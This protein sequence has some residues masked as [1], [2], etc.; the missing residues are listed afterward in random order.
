MALQPCPGS[1]GVSPAP[2]STNQY[3]HPQAHSP[4]IYET[5]AGET[6]ALPGGL[7]F[8]QVTMQ[9]RRLASGALNGGLPTVASSGILPAQHLQALI[10]EGRLFA[11]QPILASQVQPASLDLRLGPVAYRVRASF[12]PSARSRVLDK[13]E[14]FQMHQLDLTTPA[15]LERGCVY[16]VP[17]QEEVDLPADVSGLANP[18]STVGRLDV[19]TRL[20][21]DH[22]DEFER[23]PPGY[24]GQLYAE[25]APRTFSVLV[26]QGTRMNQLRLARGKEET[27]H[28]VL[29]RLHE[30]ETLVYQGN[31]DP[32]EPKI[33]DGLWFSVDLEGEPSVAVIGYRAKRYGPL[34]DLDRVDFYDP[35]EFWEPI[36]RPPRGQLILN[37]EEFYILASKEKIRIPPTYAAE[38]VGYDASV[39]EFRI[40]YAGFFD[41]GFGYGNDDLKG[42]R[43]VLEVRSHE[44][45]FLLE[46]GQRVGRLVYERL[47]EAPDR[48]YGTAIGSSYQGQG[49]ALSK[50]FKRGI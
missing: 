23:V 49:I 10:D 50:Q 38:M 29:S 39:G 47:L 42:T 30:V 36:P 18:K 41:P 44:V 22:G 12:L 2:G 48:L 24:Q 40:H 6:P 46:D 35:A 26:R 27:P 28:G 1:A 21:T 16:I 17:L 11:R 5:G 45:P 8:A 33:A 4:A 7:R 20:I 31:G 37:P 43:A 25:I 13:V 32:G 9:T 15:V 34:V 19:F 14:Q 3:A